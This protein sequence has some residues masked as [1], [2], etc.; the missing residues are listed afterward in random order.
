MDVDE[1]KLLPVQIEFS[2]DEVV[3]F[4]SM[5]DLAL[6]NNGIQVIDHV[7]NLRTK[8]KNALM[9]QNDGPKLHT[10]K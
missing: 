6:R 8:M 3:F 4:A 9:Q 5:L 2:P 1:N 10:V 7:N